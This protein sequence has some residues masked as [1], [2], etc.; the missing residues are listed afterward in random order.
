MTKRILG[1]AA[2][3]LFSAF[4]LTPIGADAAKGGNGK[5]KGT[6]HRID[7]LS[8][9][10]ESL[11]A[12]LEAVESEISSIELTPGP[13]GETGAAGPAGPQGEPG[14]QGEQGIQGVEGPAGAEG[15]EGAE[16]PP[17]GAGGPNGIYVYARI[18]DNSPNATA[19]ILQ[20]SEGFSV[21]VKRPFWAT[22]WIVFDFDGLP[23]EE[24]MSLTV[25]AWAIAPYEDYQRALP[26][27][28]FNVHLPFTR[29]WPDGI[30]DKIRLTVRCPTPVESINISLRR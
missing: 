25:N 16:G 13:Q 11:K 30:N 23:L 28:Q 27:H 29:N 26:C 22:Q 15:P 9:T 19:E 5:K 7:T 24:V 2:V 17:G 12:Q 4:I 6:R 10:V 18:T 20:H 8:A 3:V 1:V 21:S 14:P